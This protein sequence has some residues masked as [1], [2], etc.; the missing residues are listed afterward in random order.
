M[1]DTVAGNTKESVLDSIL[2]N[3]Y[4]HDLFLDQ[5]NNHYARYEDGTICNVDGDDKRYELSNTS[6]FLVCKNQ[7]KANNFK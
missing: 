5:E 2:I 7:T 4:L 6:Y 3:I 1:E